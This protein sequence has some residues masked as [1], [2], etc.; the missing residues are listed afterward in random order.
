MWRWYS[1]EPIRVVCF[2]GVGQVMM[3]DEVMAITAVYEAMQY[4]LSH[5]VE[6]W[7]T[8]FG[9]GDFN[10]DGI[11]S[12]QDLDFFYEY[13]SETNGHTRAEKFNYGTGNPANR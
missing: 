12:L 13:Y 6:K 5:G 8:V 11:I 1:M 9:Q 3:T 2:E 7:P 10:N 4:R